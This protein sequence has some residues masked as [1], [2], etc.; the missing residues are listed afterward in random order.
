MNRIDKLINILTMVKDH[1][2]TAYE[3]GK[4]TKISTFAVQKILNGETKKPNELT[5]DAII[6]FLETRIINKE[7]DKLNLVN[8]ISEPYGAKTLSKEDLYKKVIHL[9]EENHKLIKEKENLTK[10][11]KDN[12]ID[13]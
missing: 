1:N 3:I 4:N 7:S 2:I 11:L 10:K 13:Y 5:L 12:G 8:E 9:M 6:D